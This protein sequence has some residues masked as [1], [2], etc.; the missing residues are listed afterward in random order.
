MLGDVVKVY[1]TM[2]RDL[3]TT[4]ETSRPLPRSIILSFQSSP[5]GTTPQTAADQFA[6]HVMPHGVDSVTDNVVDALS[7]SPSPLL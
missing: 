7:S 1:F 5:S 2:N 6:D 3:L 4:C